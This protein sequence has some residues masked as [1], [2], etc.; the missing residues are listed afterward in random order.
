MYPAKQEKKKNHL[1]EITILRQRISELETLENDLKRA[2][3]KASHINAVLHASRRVHQL[4]VNENDI[5]KLLKGVCKNLVETRGYY[6]A[7]IALL[8]ESEN[9]INSAE[10]GLGKDF[11]LM[12]KRLKNGKLPACG[13]LALAQPDAV[14]TKDPVSICKDCLLSKAYHGRGAMS[15]RL[16]HGG[17]TYGLLAISIPVEYTDDNEERSLFKEIADDIALALYSLE[18]AE[19]HRR[20]KESLEESERR[21]RDL[22]NGASDALCIRDLKGNIL[23]VNRA[24]S[25]ITGYTE[26]ELTRLHISQILTPESVDITM[27]RQQR[28]LKGEIAGQRYELELIRKDG[29]RTIIDLM[30]SIIHKNGQPVA[31]QA[32]IRDVTEQKR[33]K[34]NM[35]FYIAE[36]TKAQEE[37]RDE[38]AQDLAT[39]LLDFDAIIEGKER[40]PE[41]TLHLVDQLRERAESIMEGVRRFSHELR[42]AIL[43]QLGLLPALEWLADDINVSYGIDA[44]IKVNGTKRRFSPDVELLMFRIAQEA[45]RNVQKHSRASKTEIVVEF[46]EDKT[47]MTI[48]DNGKGFDVGE[49]LTELPRTGKLGLAGMEER[50][51]LLGGKLRIQSE[52]GKGTSITVEAPI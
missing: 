46:G 20:A 9:L 11:K 13:R 12:V 14:V 24:M 44:N 47:R 10:T 40:M 29:M 30:I 34:E 17:K 6:N 49:S 31:I 2:E 51:R 35:S 7:W 3:E 42:P 37:E 22:F 41:T 19:E 15:A 27:E 38:T 36:I 21:Y 8:D 39:L 43:D 52:P 23:E 50:V 45:F 1:K 18:H 26:M 4:L 32:N 33:L 28:R 16:E 5:E 25:D 48:Y